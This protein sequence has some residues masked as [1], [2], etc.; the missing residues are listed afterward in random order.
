M[1]IART[2]KVWPILVPPGQPAVL[3]FM[4]VLRAETYEEKDAMIRKWMTAVWESWAD[5]HGWV[6][7][8][9]DYLLIS[10]RTQDF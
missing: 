8:M 2:K 5:R 10:T 7:A 4:D 9:T 6:R 3:T 1:S